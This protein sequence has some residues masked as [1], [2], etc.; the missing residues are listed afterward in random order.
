MVSWCYGFNKWV[1]PEL[2]GKASSQ[3]VLCPYRKPTQVGR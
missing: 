1:A 2:P 3:N